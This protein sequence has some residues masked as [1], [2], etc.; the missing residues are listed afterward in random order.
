MKESL[1]MH[2]LADVK[3]HATK[4]NHKLHICLHS[5]IL[6]LFCKQINALARTHRIF[7][8]LVAFT[9][10]KAFHGL[11]LKWNNKQTHSHTHPKILIALIQFSHFRFFVPYVV[12]LFWRLSPVILDKCTHKWLENDYNDFP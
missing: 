6:C 1:R 12:I 9:L 7:I 5:I 3:T 4:R 11:S 2:H 8:R 10:S